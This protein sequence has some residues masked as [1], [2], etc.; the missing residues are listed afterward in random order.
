MWKRSE[1]KEA[2]VKSLL[3]SNVC[4]R[5]KLSVRILRVFFI[6]ASNDQERIK[7][8]CGFSST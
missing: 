8:E 2:R 4:E 7:G 5:H 1:E 6:K 3:H